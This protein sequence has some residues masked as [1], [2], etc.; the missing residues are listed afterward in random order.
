[1]WAL[2]GSGWDLYEDERGE[3]AHSEKS[4]SRVVLTDTKVSESVK[5]AHELVEMPQVTE[6]QTDTEY[7]RLNRQNAVTSSAGPNILAATST[8]SVS[9]DEFVKKEPGVA[10]IHGISTPADSERNH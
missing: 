10:E 6:V 8:T 3:S 7:T 4:T 5:S 1:M 9:V 2:F